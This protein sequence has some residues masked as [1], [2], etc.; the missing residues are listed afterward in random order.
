VLQGAVTEIVIKG[1]ADTAMNAKLV[2]ITASGQAW[3][4]PFMLV[5]Q[6]ANNSIPF[7]LFR[8]DSL[9]LLPRPYP[10][11]QP[12]WFQGNHATALDPA[13]VERIQIFMEP[14]LNPES[15]KTYSM[16]IH[17]VRIK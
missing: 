14:F 1:R 6:V 10:G 2:L 11:F 16:D 13:D 15:G 17:S 5:N 3:S 7:S 9:L 8:P 4:A 12:M